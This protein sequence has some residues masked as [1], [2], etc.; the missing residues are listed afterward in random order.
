MQTLFCYTL[1][2]WLFVCP[3]L[4]LDIIEAEHD[5]RNRFYSIF[6]RNMFG[7]IGVNAKI[8][9]KLNKFHTE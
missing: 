3:V 5:I 7:V 1:I 9:S 8:E 4:L 6:R 2:T